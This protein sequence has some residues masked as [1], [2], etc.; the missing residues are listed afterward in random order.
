[1]THH[2]LRSKHEGK[3]DRIDKTWV[4]VCMCLTEGDELSEKQFQLAC[5]CVTLDVDA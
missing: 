1:M 4:F 5:G 2:G 3:R